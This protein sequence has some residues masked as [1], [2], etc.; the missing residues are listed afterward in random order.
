M[1]FLDNPGIAAICSLRRAGPG[2]PGVKLGCPQQR[3]GCLWVMQ[4]SKPKAEEKIRQ[5]RYHSDEY[6]GAEILY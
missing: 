1:P 5:I 3:S 2:A 4:R 6:M